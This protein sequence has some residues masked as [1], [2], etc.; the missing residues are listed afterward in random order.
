AGHG[1]T[2][3]MLNNCE[4]PSIKAPNAAPTQGNQGRAL[5]SSAS[6]EPAGMIVSVFKAA[7]KPL[8]METM[9]TP[10]LPGGHDH[11]LLCYEGWQ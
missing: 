2:D 11:F 8:N 5:W 1:R 9:L 7:L 3:I 4:A 6:L 10:F